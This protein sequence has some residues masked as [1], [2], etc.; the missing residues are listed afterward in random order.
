MA[1]SNTA[2]TLSHAGIADVNIQSE[3]KQLLIT[4]AQETTMKGL[5]ISIESDTRVSELPRRSGITMI[6]LQEN[7]D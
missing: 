3:T 5:E 2:G 7:D 6:R 4:R 1:I